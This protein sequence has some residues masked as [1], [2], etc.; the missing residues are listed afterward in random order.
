MR[1]FNNYD[2]ASDLYYKHNKVLNLNNQIGFEIVEFSPAYS[3]QPAKSEESNV[4]S[5][6]DGGM[7]RSMRFHADNK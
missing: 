5:S 3:K 1:G 4:R 6:S 7:I 2:V